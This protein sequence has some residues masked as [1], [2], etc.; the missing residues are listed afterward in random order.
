MSNEF[1]K[2]IVPGT[3]LEGT[4]GTF[5]FVKFEKIVVKIPK[6]FLAAAYGYGHYYGRFYGHT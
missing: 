3:I 4:G 2:V 6:E 1:K 5:T